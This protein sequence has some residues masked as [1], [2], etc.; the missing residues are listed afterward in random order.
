MRIQIKFSLQRT[1]LSARTVMQVDVH[2]ELS[3]R[4]K[5]HLYIDQS[6][7]Q[8]HCRIKIQCY[9]YMTYVT[10]LYS[11]LPIQFFLYNFSKNLLSHN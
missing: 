11:K 1:I 9:E 7:I 5:R 6:I 10:S 2:P 8:I 3:Q 4:Y